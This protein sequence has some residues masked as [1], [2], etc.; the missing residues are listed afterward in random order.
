MFSKVPFNHKNKSLF[1]IAYEVKVEEK[2]MTNQNYLYS[3]I[4]NTCDVLYINLI[5]I[6]CSH[7][8]S[9]RKNIK[10]AFEIFERLIRYSSL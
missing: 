10:D 8:P 6:L 4:D 3:I 7:E 5:K 9:K 1:D 2:A